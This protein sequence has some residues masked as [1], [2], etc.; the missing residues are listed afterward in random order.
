[1]NKKLIYAGLAL[2]GM[3]STTACDDFLDVEP[4]SGFTSDYVFSSDDEIKSLMTQIYSSM[5]TDGLYGSTLVYGLNTN[6]D[7]EFSSYSN[8]TVSTSGA[9]IGCFDSRPYWSTL[10]SLWNNLYSVINYA[11]DFIESVEALPRF[12]KEVGEKG[13]SELQQMYGEVKTLRALFYL[14]LIR[15]W[16]DVV[17]VTEPSKSTDDFFA[18]GT[19]DR[20]EILEFLID[21][22]KS[23]EPMMLYAESLDYGVERASR[24]YCQALIGQL[25]LYRGGWTLRPDTTNAA[26][27]G[28]MQRTA[29]YLDYYQI[30]KEYLGKVIS[31]GKHSL[32]QSFKELWHNECNWKLISNDDVLF[33]VPMLKGT[34]GQFGYRIGVTITEG[35]H[36]YGSA[37]NYVHY[38]P[39]YIYTFDTQ[40]LRRDI[41]CVPYK[42]DENL[43]QQIDMGFCAMG[44]GKWNKL[45]MESP[46]GSTS[47][48]GTG[49]NSIR[50]RYAD[51][52]LMY[53]EV[54]NELSG[55]IAEA[56]EALKQV[57][58]RAFDS[59]LWVDKVETYVESLGTKED[60]FKAI[61]DERMWEFGG[62]GIRKYDLARW[63]KYGEVIYNLYNQLINW[64]LVANGMY[65]PGVEKVPE[66]I[67]YMEKQDPNYPDRTILDIYGI[68]QYGPDMVIPSGKKS[69]LEYAKAWR[70]LDKETQEFVITDAIYW[71][72]RGF[73]NE[74]NDDFV[75][76]TDPV[77]YLCPYPSKVI[78]DHRGKI[79]NYYAY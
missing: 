55:P 65:I 41:T 63:N 52:L 53:A 42:Y 27:V 78:T 37:R 67:Y 21:D 15:T 30:A 61:M 75:Q 40:D 6:T 50:M 49:I 25:A 57:R 28:T 22:L 9:D 46:L 16:G 69:E 4:G 1:M 8:N 47:G 24:E 59:S 38:T 36:A 2:C 11:N 5:T 73:I 3:L 74:G 77:R 26:S 34:T 58:R 56:K 10:N 66:T 17:F 76:P 23:V 44:I 48:S 12:T 33:E 71:S 45:Y 72:F 51:V 20:N 64:A 43:N 18:K 54:V 31:E 29:D 60:F 35:D 62:E 13:P 14:D 39:T 19:T 32:T 68:D 7:V 79:K 70:V